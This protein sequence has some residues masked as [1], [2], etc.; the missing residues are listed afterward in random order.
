MKPSVWEGGRW[1]TYLGEQP[2]PPLQHGFLG[3][4]IHLACSHHPSSLTRITE[5]IQCLGSPWPK[6]RHHFCFA[7]RLGVCV[8]DLHAQEQPAGEPRCPVSHG[9]ARRERT[10][11]RRDEELSAHESPV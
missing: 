1:I 4:G 10:V 3:A 2:S 5:A 11:R 6:P 9:S 8:R 7:C